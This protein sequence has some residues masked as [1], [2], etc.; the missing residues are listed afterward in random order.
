MQKSSSD[1]KFKNNKSRTPIELQPAKSKKAKGTIDNSI[2]REEEEKK[3]DNP[4]I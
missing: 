1:V 2:D 4:Q 3:K